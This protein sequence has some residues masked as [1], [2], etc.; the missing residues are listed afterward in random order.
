MRQLA[1]LPHKVVDF[2]CLAFGGRSFCLRQGVLVNLLGE[3]IVRHRNILHSRHSQW[4]LLY[5]QQ[6]S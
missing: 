5:Q 4:P 3:G 6:L 2:P 1:E